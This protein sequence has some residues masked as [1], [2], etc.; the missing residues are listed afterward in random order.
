MQEGLEKI[1]DSVLR[2]TNISELRFPSTLKTIHGAAF[3][4]CN[5]L[6]KF[7]LD[8]NE[9]FVYES[10]LLM[11]KSKE[12]IIYISSKAIQ[13]LTTFEIPEGIESFSTDISRYTNLKGITIPIS[14]NSINMQYLPTSIENIDVKGGNNKYT[15]ENGLLY[16][17]DNKLIGCYSKQNNI[18][19][20]EGIQELE[21]YSFKLA[22]NAEVIN[23]PDSLE[24]INQRVF[25]SNSKIKEINI[26][27]NV[28][29]IH[30]LFKLYNFNGVVNIDSEN[31]YYEV[32]DNILYKKD[33]ETQEGT[34]LVKVLYKI[35][36]TIKIKSSVRVIGSYSFYGQ[37][38][39][40]E[41]SIPEGVETIENTAFNNCTVRKVEIPSTV[42]T[43]GSNCFSDAT[44]NLEEIIIHNTEGSIQGAPWGAVKGMRVVQWVG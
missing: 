1:G 21:V 34:T 6:D 38:G 42:K 5:N 22:T 24:K 10:G 2:G 12:T 32:E 40:T 19:V 9:Y 26:G 7:N 11:T 20:P 14:L 27:K 30:P 17:S 28:S 41:I 3:S 4:N 33:E 35:D 44:N 25:E 36:G 29:Y 13:N 18:T 39:L 15:S 23:L 8:N 43:I 31:K 16:T 37:S